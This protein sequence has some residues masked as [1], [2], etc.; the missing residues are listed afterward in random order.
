MV[1]AFRLRGANQRSPSPQRGEGW[2]NAVQDLSRSFAGFGRV[3]ERR[4]I[5]AKN[6]ISDKQAIALS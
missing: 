5:G 6:P 4:N 2:A 1:N 3:F